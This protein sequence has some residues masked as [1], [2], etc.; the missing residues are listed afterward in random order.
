LNVPEI[1]NLFQQSEE[2][3][4]RRQIVH[5]LISEENLDRKTDLHNPLLWAAM[6]MIRDQLEQKGL[7]GASRILGE[8]RVHGMRYLISDKRKGR[9]E[10]IEALKAV[11]ADSLRPEPNRLPRTL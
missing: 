8:F 6:E 5:E 2:L 7:S 4:V 9:G 10:Y 1:D 11:G 3:D